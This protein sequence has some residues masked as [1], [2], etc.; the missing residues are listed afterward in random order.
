MKKFKVTQIKSGIDRPERQKLTLQALGLTRLNASREVEATPQILGMI[1]AVNH[2]I[3]V[4]EVSAGSEGTQEAAPVE[5][6]VEAGTQ[7]GTFAQLEESSQVADVSPV[8]E[9][10][11]AEEVSPAREDSQTDAGNDEEKAAEP[12]NA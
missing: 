9:T 6:T 10:T 2:L 5:N 12:G 1:R 8:E 3:K 7:A 11:Q 4:E